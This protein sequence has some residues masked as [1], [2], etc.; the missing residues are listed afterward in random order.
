MPNCTPSRYERFLYTTL[1]LLEHLFGSH[2]RLVQ[3]REN[4]SETI[5]SNISLPDTIPVEEVPHR[6]GLSIQEFIKEY[7]N[8]LKPVVLKG[9]AKEWPACNRW[10]PDFFAQ[11]YASVPVILFDGAVEDIKKETS[12]PAHFMSLQE[13]VQAMQ[14]GSQ[15]YARFLPILEKNPELMSD[16]D[17]KWLRSA[18]HRF[19]GGMKYQFFMGGPKTST[20]MH[21]ALGANLFVQVYGQKQWWIYS[22]KNT[23]LM[24]P[25]MDRS[26]FFRSQVSSED[27]EGTFQKARGWTTILEPGDIL[28]NP[29]FFWHQARNLD[30][31][32]GVGFRW[33]A[34]SSMLRSS[35]AQ[36]FM[37]ITASNPSLRTVRRL[38]GNFARVYAEALEGTVR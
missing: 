35:A 5:A 21:S 8:P 12:A 10:S 28:Y 25:A 26:I 3:T 6:R 36:L 31:S 9:A 19:G 11:Q 18:A 20:S 29:P 15:E 34:L 30:M 32:I 37:T 13:F 14:S 23:P 1:W 22:T 33:Y 16:F 38:N 27:P 17:S 7:R 24:K 4:L 2:Q